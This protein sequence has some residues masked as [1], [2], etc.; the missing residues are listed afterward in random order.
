MPNGTSI[1]IQLPD[2]KHIE[3]RS[4]TLALLHIKK[5][6]GKHL[7]S[8][9]VEIM[10]IDK[11]GHIAQKDRIVYQPRAAVYEKAYPVPPEIAQIIGESTLIVKRAAEPLDF[12]NR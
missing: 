4:V 11:K 12:G 10:D 2:R 3:L 7:N 1:E 5:A 9:A 6:F 8:Y